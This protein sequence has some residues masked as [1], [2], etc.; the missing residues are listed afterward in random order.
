M[1]KIKRF[2]VIAGADTPAAQYSGGDDETEAEDQVDHALMY[3]TNG[4]STYP[5]NSSKSGYTRGDFF[6]GDNELDLELE[7]FT[8]GKDVYIPQKKLFTTNTNWLGIDIRIRPPQVPEQ[9]D[10]TLPN[11][12]FNIRH[13]IQSRSPPPEQFPNQ[14]SPDTNEEVQAVALED[15]NSGLLTVNSF[16]KV[17]FWDPSS[18]V[19]DALRFHAMMGDVQT[20]ACVLIVLGEQRRLLVGL[21]EATQEH[22]LLGYIELLGR[23]RLW[24]V[25]AQ[26]SL[27]P[28]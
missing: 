17:V 5:H 13:E 27:F 1:R 14:N 20:A 18:L 6:F 9:Q 19:I 12:A 22:W 26:V 21:D 11:E 7:G 8:Q 2:V 15:Q 16:P 10:W 23:C 3:T 28:H 25:A 24:N 4:F